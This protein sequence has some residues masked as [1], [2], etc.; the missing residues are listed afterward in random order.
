M[1]VIVN[2]GEDMEINKIKLG[3]FRNISTCEID[4]EK[5]TGLL[6]V[7]SYGKSNLLK[8]I[9]FG[10][11]FITASIN[12]KNDLLGLKSAFPKNRNSLKTEFEFEM[13]LSCKHK[14]KRYEIK[15]KYSFNWRLNEESNSKI[16]SEYLFVREDSKNKIFS[17][18]IKRDA[19]KA[20]FKSTETG[21][22]NKKILINDEELVLNKLLAYDELFY[23][24]IIKEMN[25]FEIYIDRH[26]DS[27][28]A[29]EV[30]P[31]VRKNS[32]D[33]KL[34]TEANI[35]RTLYK[36]SKIYPNK[37]DYLIDIYKQLFPKIEKIEIEEFKVGGV[38]EP[39]SL[40]EDFGFEIV[41][42]VYVLFCKEHNVVSG[43]DFKDM[44]DGARRILLLLTNLLLAEI[45]NV[46]LFCIEE[47]ENSINPSLLR[48][49]IEVINDISNDTK[50]LITSH[51]PYLI[52]YLNPENLYIGSFD[53]RDLVNFKQV[54]KSAVN[55]LYK[56]A[57]DNDMSYGD[58]L[59]DL[60][61]DEDNIEEIE[62]YVKK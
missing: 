16:N 25:S 26:L 20:F 21:R 12:K 47:P 45:N 4:I 15:Y 5:I 60:F 18:Y 48:K 19:D 11:D 62:K 39:G 41:D 33:L 46:P 8:G 43:I 27:S 54:K 37:Y 30:D 32:D 6:S 53:K 59:F 31:F 13:N 55:K 7:N 49:Y 42:I 61:S 56:D 22:C 44:S 10:I 50:I 51:S 3:G 24:D 23:N 40:P 2:G 34:A 58:Y 35:P 14:E 38:P 17:Q 28:R 57:S 36:L 1:I 52:E 29:F 9:E